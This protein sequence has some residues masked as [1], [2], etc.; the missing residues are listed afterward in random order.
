[1]Q[2]HKKVIDGP[3]SEAGHTNQEEGK[4]EQEGKDAEHFHEKVDKTLTL[5]SLYFYQ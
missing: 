2:S 5:C 1:L 4:Q 3:S